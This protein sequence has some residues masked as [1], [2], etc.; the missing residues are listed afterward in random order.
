[1]TLIIASAPAGLLYRTE[2]SPLSKQRR[3]HCWPSPVV[4]ESMP[5]DAF[6]VLTSTRCRKAF[7]ASPLVLHTATVST[8]IACSVCCHIVGA[9]GPHCVGPRG[10]RYGQPCLIYLHGISSVGQRQCLTCVAGASASIGPTSMARRPPALASSAAGSMGLSSSN[11][12]QQPSQTRSL[13]ADRHSRSA[14]GLSWSSQRSRNSEWA[15]Q[16][17]QTALPHRRQW[18]FGQSSFENRPLPSRRRDC[19]FANALFPLLLKHLLTVEGG[20]AEWQN[21]RRRLP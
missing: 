16:P 11:S 12:A 4:K 9:P 15:E 1:M 14:C 10:Q 21:S 7:L 5:G 18:C 3:L 17:P 20:A 2:C 6:H 19:H 8:P 13:S